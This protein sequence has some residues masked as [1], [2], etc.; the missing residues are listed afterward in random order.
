MPPLCKYTRN[1]ALLFCYRSN[2][3]IIR[4]NAS[5]QPIE[6]W[7]KW[8]SFCRRFRYTIFFLIE[9]FAFLM[10][11][12]RNW[13]QSITWVNVQ[14]IYIRTW[15]AEDRCLLA[16]IRKN[17]MNGRWWNYQQ[18]WDIIQAM[19]RDILGMFRVTIWIQDD[20]CFVGQNIS[21][22]NITGKFRNVF[23]WNFQENLAM[24]GSNHR[25]L[26]AS[27]ARLFHASRN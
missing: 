1:T 24:I 20:F 9:K 22:G 14:V 8:M 27:L 19:T 23:S 17:S 16:P 21:F 25:R 7:T 3:R 15:I 6:T 4:Y 13:C 11:F 10:K 18:I 12:H 5:Y 26:R 2:S